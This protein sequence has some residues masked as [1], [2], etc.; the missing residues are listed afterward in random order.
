MRRLPSACSGAAARSGSGSRD[1]DVGRDRRRRARP[2]R[3]RSRARA[4][5]LRRPP[6][7]ALAGRATRTRSPTRSPTSS[8]SSR[9][10]RAASGAAA[11][12]RR[13]TNRGLV[14]RAPARHRTQ[15][16]R[17]GAP[18][19]RGVRPRERQGRRDLVGPDR[20]PRDRG[21]PA[22]RAAN[23]PRRERRRALRRAG[24]AAA[25]IR[26]PRRPCASSPSTTTSSSPTPTARGSATR[27]TGRGSASATTA[28][29]SCCWSAASSA[30]RG[31]SWTAT[32]SSSR[33]GRLS[34]RDAAAVE[35]EGR[36]LA[37]LP[38]RRRGAHTPG[39]SGTL[40][41]GASG[42]SYPS[43]KGGFYPADAKAGGL[44]APLRRAGE[45]GRAQQHVLPRPARGPVRP[46]GGAGAGRVPLRA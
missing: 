4:R 32:W 9:S 19:P 27:P 8:R 40:Y 24:R 16:G 12:G 11:G 39:V 26:T 1:V 13:W 6:R 25:P 36:R 10:R 7:R 34:K 2:P 14:A 31:G 44:P 18:L 37:A 41:A 15:A 3:R 28:S 20:R 43:W 33:R 22:R 38:G 30:R 46:L 5:E 29:S 17:G 21:A 35:A 45:R 23:V 42:F